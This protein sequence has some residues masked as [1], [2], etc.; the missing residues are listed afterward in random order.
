MVAR[1]YLLT[2]CVCIVLIAGVN[3][4]DAR[5]NPFSTKFA[6]KP[7]HAIL[8]IIDGL[9]YKVWDRMNL[10]VLDRMRETGAVV[11]QDYLPPAAHPVKGPYAEIH[12]CSIPN[13]ILMAGTVF[14]TRETTYL[15]DSFFPERTTAFS[16]NSTSYI[17]LSHHYHYVYQKEGGDGDAI[18]MALSFMEIGAP[19]FTHIHLQNPGGAGSQNFDA[20]PEKSWRWNIWAEDSPYRQAIADADSL[21]GELIH[22]LE[23]LGV[24]NKTVLVIL[25]DHGQN[26]TGWHPLE[27]LDSSITTVVMWGAGIKKGVRIP[28]AEHI[29][30]VPTVCTLMDVNPPVTSQGRVIGE[31]LARF[32][33]IAPPRKATQKELNELLIEYRKKVSEAGFRLESL[34]SGKQGYLFS[35]LNSGVRDEFYDIGKFSEW[36][37]FQSLDELLAHDRGV[38]KVLDEILGE[39]PADR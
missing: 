24:L 28:Y 16:A 8:V 17:T 38:M 23:R 15:Q 33:G 27:Y 30:I 12:S 7:E 4:G 34:S 14:I 36:S 29:D 13:P 5:A 9:S 35:R 39:L 31:A 22:G 25:G 6:D 3:A 18:T 10:P 20:A 26:D 1:G 11:E 2:W 21:V 19:A 32:K 37:R